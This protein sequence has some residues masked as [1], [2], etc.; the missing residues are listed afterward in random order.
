MYKIAIFY[1]LSIGTGA[2]FVFSRFVPKMTRI[3]KMA[4]KTHEEASG[5]T[6]VSLL[7]KAVLIDTKPDKKHRFKKDPSLST[8]PC[9]QKSNS[10]PRRDRKLQC[11][12]CRKT[13]HTIQRCPLAKTLLK[14]YI[15]GSTEHSITRCLKPKDPL[16]PFPFASCF[17][18]QETGH[19]SGH[20]PQNER[21]VYPKGGSCV[22]CGEYSYIKICNSI[23]FCEAFGKRL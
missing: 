20:C 1:R 12:N 9:K 21:G 4:K 11:F 7:P 19:I 22:H 3:T 10:V 23:R 6:A 17:I 15:C 14:C 2:T 13:G 5:F 8:L 16:N 18:C